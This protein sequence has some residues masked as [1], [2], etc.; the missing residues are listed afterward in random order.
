[1]AV[2]RLS[3][4]PN[5]VKDFGSRIRQNL[6]V[7]RRAGQSL[8]TSATSFAEFLRVKI[9]KGVAPLP[10]P[11]RILDDRKF[12]NTSSKRKRVDLMAAR[13]LTRWRFELVCYYESS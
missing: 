5:A 6:E 9:L 7:L 12:D 13:G 1:M 4:S 2:P 8:A 3:P 10:T 11:L